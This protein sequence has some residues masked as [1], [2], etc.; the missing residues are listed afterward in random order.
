[1]NALGLQ[2]KVDLPSAS[3]Q[4]K[5]PEDQPRR[6]L[7]S[8]VRIKTQAGLA[9]PNVADGHRNPQLSAPRLR[10]GGVEHTCAQDAEFEL[11][12]AALHAEKQ[13]IIG[14]TGIIHAVEIDDPGFHKAAELEKMVPI[15][16]VPGQAGGVETKDGSHV[17]GAEPCDK[18]LEPRSGYCSACRAAKVVV[19]DFDIPESMSSGLIDKLVLAPLALEVDLNLERSGLADVNDGLPLQERRGKDLTVHHRL[20]PRSRRRPLPSAGERGARS[21]HCAPEC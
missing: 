12:D 14:P 15:P 8:G 17:A 19:D 1:M 2:G 18:L 6:F 20:P 11:A 10:T 16:T 3:K 21:P 7:D 4:A 5:S 9:M 13:P